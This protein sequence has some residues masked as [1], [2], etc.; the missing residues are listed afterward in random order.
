MGEE[1]RRYL[2][3]FVGI[4][5]GLAALY[6]AGYFIVTGDLPPNL[7]QEGVGIGSGWD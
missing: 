6:C 7:F 5:F 2:L 4:P 1:I 3:V